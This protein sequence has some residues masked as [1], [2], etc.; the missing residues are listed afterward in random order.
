MYF[1]QYWF[2]YNTNDEKNHMTTKYHW[3]RHITRGFLAFGEKDFKCRF[4]F[5]FK[6]TN[7][8]FKHNTKNDWNICDCV[9][10]KW[11]HLITTLKHQI[12]KLDFYDLIYHRFWIMITHLNLRI[13][14][15]IMIDFEIWFV[16]A[17]LNERY[18]KRNY[19]SQLKNK[20]WFEQ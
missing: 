8:D 3:I 15:R 5:Q 13:M 19:Y 1:K 20:W 18:E 2:V 12:I 11:I 16:I 6:M 17:G 4:K 9:F 10:H 14:K 7:L